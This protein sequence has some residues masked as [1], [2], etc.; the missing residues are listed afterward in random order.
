MAFLIG[1]IVTHFPYAVA[2]AS[3]TTDAARDLFAHLVQVYRDKRPE[4]LRGMVERR[5]R[6]RG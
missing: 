4:Y 6:R 5:Y 2:A 1:I 3:L